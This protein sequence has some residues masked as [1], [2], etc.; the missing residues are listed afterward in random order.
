MI[1]GISVV[2]PGFGEDE[3]LLFVPSIIRAS[4]G[5]DMFSLAV[6]LGKFNF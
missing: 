1:L 6:N 3:D 5:F 2:S 4:L